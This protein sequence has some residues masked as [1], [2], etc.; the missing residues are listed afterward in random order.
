M[1]DH[2]NRSYPSNEAYGRAAPRASGDDPLA[3]LARLIGQNDPFTNPAGRGAG[4]HAEPQGEWR[5]GAE[6]YG[7][8]DPRSTPAPTGYA[9]Y[10]QSG[11]GYADHAAPAPYQE[12]AYG[13]PPYAQ[14]PY[15][16]DAQG[17]PDDGYQR[18]YGAQPPQYGAPAYPPQ[19]PGYPDPYYRDGTPGEDIYEEDSVPRR[20]GGMLTVM[21]VLSLALIGTAAAFGY[22]AVFGNS[23]STPPPVIKADTTPNKIVP[24]AP[25]AEQSKLI[26]DRVGDRAQA[27]RI[28]AREEKPLDVKDSVAAAPPRVVTAPAANPMAAPAAPQIPASASALTAPG[29]PAAAAP[30]RV[31]TVSIRPDEPA[32][33]APAAR[34][35]PPANIPPAERAAPA[36]RPVA[37]MAPAQPAASIEAPPTRPAAA[38]PPAPRAAAPDPNAPMSLAPPRA[39]APAPAPR[40]TTMRTASA[41]ATSAGGAYTVQVSSRR[42]EAEAQA[43]FQSLQAQ[44]PNLLSGR[45]PIIRRADLGDKGVYYRAQVGPFATSDA[46]SEFCSSLKA[47]GGQC[48]V[49]RN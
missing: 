20:R 39:A 15:A 47:A 28:V 11:N 22:R 2:G 16:Q 23:G 5:P 49:Q 14:P 12:P 13:Q 4:A 21:A 30:K 37:A 26:Y 7:A 41:P 24:A 38:R 35:V 45:Q 46:A 33:E 27:E 17:H 44:F 36:A 1:A 31:R 3:E 6:T 32:S 42:S 29:A 34:V 19:A 43:S 48:V 9:D 10:R 18:G 25:T 8:P 40:P